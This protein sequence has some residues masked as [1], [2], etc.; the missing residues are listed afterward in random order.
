ME[1]RDRWVAI[2]LFFLSIALRLPFAGR[3]PE[4][5]DSVDFALA[6]NE[7][8]VRAM[9]PHFP[10]YP[11]FILCGHFFSFFIENDYLSLSLVSVLAGAGS[12]VLFYF[13]AREWLSP[14]WATVGAVWM[15]I[16]PLSWLTSTQPMSDSLGLLVALFMI[17]LSSRSLSLPNGARWHGMSLVL[18]GVLYSILL[19]IRLSYWPAVAILLI[20][21]MKWH[22]VDDRWDFSLQRLRYLFLS[23]MLAISGT[24]IWLW[25]ASLGEGSI[26]QFLELG[27]QFT[28][29]HFTEWGGTAL[30]E[31]TTLERL[32]A[33]LEWGWWTSIF[34]G[35]LDQEP[36]IYILGASFFILLVGLGWTVK[37]SASKRWFLVIWVLSF[38]LWTYWGQNIDKPRHLLPLLP[39]I[40]LVAMIGMSR[41]FSLLKWKKGIIILMTS[42]LLIQG[43]V[44]WQVVREHR[45]D[46]PPVLQLAFYLKEHVPPDEVLVITH[47]EERVMQVVAPSYQVEM[48]RSRT[49]L[50]RAILMHQDKEKI[51]L[52][53]AV[54]DGLGSERSWIQPYLHEITSFQGSRRI[55]PV[56]YHIRLYQLD[57]KAL[58]Q[59]L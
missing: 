6:L 29:G 57:T 14:F 10:G 48:L 35:P 51:L 38:G 17:G 32:L 34:G 26:A 4:S 44:G 39:V 37:Q 42:L 9:Q 58:L 45:F 7:Y 16:H 43:W 55:D 56:Y 52:T 2:S 27:K 40:L 36:R 46:P 8:D 53:S 31:P 54:V 19:G 33:W 12:V 21:L 47:E 3:V 28:V 11:I 22:Q 13:I 41:L 15:I 24:G 18:G 23:L 1:K 25:V 5:W 30:A 59:S 50:E 20:P 49:F